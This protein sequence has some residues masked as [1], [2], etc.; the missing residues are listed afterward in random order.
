MDRYS[1][2]VLA[3]MSR[4]G[5]MVCDAPELLDA[6]A[7][8]HEFPQQQ[9]GLVSINTASPVRYFSKIMPFLERSLK[10]GSTS[11]MH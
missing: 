9:C 1:E 4:R 10:K 6:K 5:N 2:V 11:F 3:L 7:S 8:F